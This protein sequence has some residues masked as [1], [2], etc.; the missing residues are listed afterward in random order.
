MNY[1]DNEFKIFSRQ[2]ILKVFSEEKIKLLERSKIT[3]IGLGGIGCP[4]ATY[5][6]CSGI[7]NIKLI[8]NLIDSDS[9]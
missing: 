8:I 4:L 7:K 5:L 9:E 6:T 3:I 2:F 1:S